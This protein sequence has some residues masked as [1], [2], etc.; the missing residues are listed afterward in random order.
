[1]KGNIAR[2]VAKVIYEVAERYDFRVVEPV[3]MSDHVHMVVSAPMKWL[4]PSIQK[5]KEMFEPVRKEFA[6]IARESP[7]RFEKVHVLTQPFTLEGAIGCPE[8]RNYP[9]L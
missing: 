7:L 5:G 8:E 2:Y 9:L 6:Q 3:L 4:Q 1:M